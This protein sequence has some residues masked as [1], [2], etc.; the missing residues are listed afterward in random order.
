MKVIFA[1]AL[2]ILCIFSNSV[3]AV[4]EIS[5]AQLETRNP[6]FSPSEA[7]TLARAFLVKEKKVI[8]KNY[9]LT[10]L[11]YEYF[12]QWESNEALF[13]GEW[14]VGFEL[15]ASP[16]YPGS[17]IGVTISNSKNPIIKFIPSE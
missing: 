15:A 10:N 13:A 12:N 11:S 9:R 1:S 6:I 4:K 2:L 3:F 17:S 14:V 16:P 8:I 5:S 7:I